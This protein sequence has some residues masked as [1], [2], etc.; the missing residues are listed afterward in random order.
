MSLAMVEGAVMS[1]RTGNRVVIADLLEASYARAIADEE[2]L[3]VR[4]RLQAWGTAQAGIA[5]GHWGVAS[6][7]P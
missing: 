5:T 6:R 7:L 1:A 4:D 3:D 2:R